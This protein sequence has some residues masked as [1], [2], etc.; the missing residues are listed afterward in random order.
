M[1]RQVVGRFAPS[2]TGHLHLGSLVTAV[3]SFCATKAVGGRW[4]LRLEDTDSARTSRAFA[5]SILAD[6]D[7]LGLHWDALSYQSARQDT[8]KSLMEDAK[9]LIYPCQC[10]RKTLQGHAIYPRLCVGAKLTP[11]HTKWRLMLPDSH[12]VFYD[13]IQGIQWQN[14][15]QSLGD[16]VIYREHIVNYIWACAI[17]DGLQGVN[18][19]VRGLDI[20]PMTAAQLA[21]QQLLR[22]PTP[23]TFYHLPLLYNACGQK[24]SKQTL[25][26]PL[27]TR[28][29]DQL[30]I[31]AL[32]LLE[33]D[34]NGLIGL[35]CQQI[36]A[37]ACTRWDIRPLQ[38]Q[39]SI[40]GVFS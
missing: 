9:V 23:D 27:D 29:P 18:Q 16:V 13:G 38:G 6:L 21:I 14:P 20:L 15:Q 40:A 36:L 24:L 4:L 31:N 12:Y 1:A 19:L 22:L 37:T 26:T 35:D 39:Q 3:A 28:K 10:S 30:L 11:P 8:Y 34:T 5:D 17:D 33:Q 7:K 25:A 32:T 2:P